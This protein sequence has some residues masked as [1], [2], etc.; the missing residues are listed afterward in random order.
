MWSVNK[1]ETCFNPFL[2]NVEDL[3]DKRKYENYTMMIRSFLTENKK[4]VIFNPYDFNYVENRNYVLTETNSPKIM[5]ENLFYFMNDCCEKIIFKTENEKDL[6]SQVAFSLLFY[7]PFVNKVNSI[8]YCYENNI[9][10]SESHE[11]RKALFYEALK[12]NNVND[13]QALFELVEL[14]YVDID[15]NDVLKFG[16]LGWTL[17]YIYKRRKCKVELGREFEMNTIENNKKQ[18][19]IKQEEFEQENQIYENI[20]GTDNEVDTLTYKTFQVLEPYLEEFIKYIRENKK[21]KEVV[22]IKSFFRKTVEEKGHKEIIKYMN[23]PPKECITCLIKYEE[24]CI[25]HKS[26]YTIDE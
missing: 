3:V 1:S 25:K 21:G 26:L 15:L 12:Q 6:F 13:Y 16:K 7:Y 18:F 14:G 5:D 24:E 20:E 23:N 9:C 2:K 11:E 19:F 22:D 4:E 10:F 17:Y 8:R